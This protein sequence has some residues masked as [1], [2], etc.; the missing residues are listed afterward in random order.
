MRILCVHQGYEHYGSDRSFIDCVAG[1]RH[2]WPG[3][4]IEVVV[5]RDGPIVL[6]LRKIASR[7]VIEP[8]LVLRRRHIIKLISVGLFRLLPALWRA[9]A[10]ARTA[11]LVYVS[12]I[13]VLDY[14]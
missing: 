3:A 13:V 5:R 2:A 9:I 8:I 10:R 6:P 7:V 12:T 1:A 11:D 4:E 14:L